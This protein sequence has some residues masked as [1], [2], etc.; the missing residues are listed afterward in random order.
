MKNIKFKNIKLVL[1]LGFV[2]LLIITAVVI[3]RP[4]QENSPLTNPL[5][6]RPK[7]AEP[8]QTNKEY[9][10]PAGFSFEFPDNLSIT[11][12]EIEDNKTYADL[13]L[14]SKDVSGNLTLKITDS[15]FT[16]IDEWLKINK[17]ATVGDPKEVKLGNLKAVEIKTSDRLLLAALDQ[18][19]LFTIE[20]PL[21]EESF[22]MKVCNQIKTGFSF[23][24]PDNTASSTNAGSSTADVS[25]EGEEVIE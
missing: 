3:F 25:F 24:L 8:S 18:D 19:I 16:T 9:A 7:T 6:P 22:W 5:I 14:T 10:D 4:G 23:E 15:K 11:K 20:M 17:E 1:I 21:V 13:Q 2:V 12:N